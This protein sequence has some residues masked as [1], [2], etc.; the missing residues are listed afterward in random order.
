MS[1]SCH[2][3]ATTRCKPP[4]YGLSGKLSTFESSHARQTKTLQTQWFAGFF[5]FAILR[6]FPL[7]MRLVQ[8]IVQENW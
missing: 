8:K 5:Y 4:F 6:I 7:K 1:L 2:F 3:P